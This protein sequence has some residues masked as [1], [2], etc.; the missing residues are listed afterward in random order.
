MLSETTPTIPASFNSSE[1]FSPLPIAECF[2]VT[3][4]QISLLGS[5]SLK[6]S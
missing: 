6:S 2:E 1:Y 3:D 4:G 5:E